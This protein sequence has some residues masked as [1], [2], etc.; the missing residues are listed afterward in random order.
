MD[1]YLELVLK[2]RGNDA[3]WKLKDEAKEQWGK[4]SRGEWGV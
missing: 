1:A 2:Q 3:M 4:G